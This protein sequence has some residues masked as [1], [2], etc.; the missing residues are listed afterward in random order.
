[1]CSVSTK[2]V[3]VQSP[4]ASWRKSHPTT[5]AHAGGQVTHSPDDDYRVLCQ[6]FRKQWAQ[7]EITMSVPAL[8]PISQGAARPC[9][10]VDNSTAGSQ[11]NHISPLNCVSRKRSFSRLPRL[12]SG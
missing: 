6:S 10:R 3:G 4:R 12:S 7:G 11:P 2:G 8:L 1:M 5:S 9:V